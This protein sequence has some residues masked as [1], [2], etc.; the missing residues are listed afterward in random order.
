MS[1]RLAAL[2]FDGNHAPVKM[3]F[4]HIAHPGE[5]VLFR[6]DGKATGDA[7]AGAG[8]ALAGMRALVEHAAFGG[9]PVFRPGL[10]HMDEG[11]LARAIQVVLERGE[12]DGIRGIRHRGR[13]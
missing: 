4:D 6:T 11:T 12:R 9:G 8:F 5:A 13:D 1:L 7:Y 3:D 10:L 2:V